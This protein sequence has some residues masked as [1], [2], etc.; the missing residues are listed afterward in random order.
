MISS[1]AT[2]GEGAIKRYLFMD[3]QTAL[4]HKRRRIGAIAGTTLKLKAGRIILTTKPRTTT[5]AAVV[6]RKRVCAFSRARW[7][8]VPLCQKR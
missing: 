2:L 1:P 6:K 8:V 7:E 5:E 3:S 4:A